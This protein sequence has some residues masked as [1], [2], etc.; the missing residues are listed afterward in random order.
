MKKV[1]LTAYTHYS[2]LNFPY[3]IVGHLSK[4]EVVIISFLRVRDVRMTQLAAA[5]TF[6]LSAS[7]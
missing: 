2:L 6:F 4:R 7:S 5:Q 1:F 3:F